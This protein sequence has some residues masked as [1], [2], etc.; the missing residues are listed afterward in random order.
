MSVTS[1][2]E[3]LIK[4]PLIPP[5]KMR[6]IPKEW[7]NP[8]SLKQKAKIRQL[9]NMRSTQTFGRC[10]GKSAKK[11]KA[12]E[13]A[14]DFSHS[15]KKHLGCPECRCSNQAGK[16]TKGDFYKLGHETGTLGVGFCLQCIR[17]HKMSM[18]VALLCAR[19]EEEALRARGS[20]EGVD[21][22]YDLKVIKAERQLVEQKAEVRV[23][24][25]LVI[26]TLDD[27][28]KQ[29]SNTNPEKRPTEMTS[30][31]PMEM[32]D[33]TRIKLCLDIATVLSRM[34]KDQFTI[35]K[36]RLVDVDEITRRV[37][38]MM[39]LLRQ[40]VAKAIELTVAKQVKGEEIETDKTPYDYVMEIG[41]EGMGAI[42]EN[43]DIKTEGGRTV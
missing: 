34:E 37:P 42:W 43:G 28:R 10:R 23:Q 33:K 7:R 35:D 31:G 9:L 26:E 16:F 41:K 30:A 4:L 12:F 29:L 14:G 15:D 27:F 18:K 25:Q 1:D 2:P 24:F 5:Q 32:S 19:R 3:L 11:I 20:V 22:D 38:Q 21:K 36:D 39:N 6:F 40:C 8:P 13:K 17:H